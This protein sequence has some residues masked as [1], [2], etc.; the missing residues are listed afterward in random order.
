MQQ[1]LHKLT[2]RDPFEIHLIPPF[3]RS[4]VVCGKVK[5]NTPRFCSIAHNR[6]D[7][8]G[9]LLQ[10]QV[11]VEALQGC[12]WFVS[13]GFWNRDGTENDSLHGAKDYGECESRPFAVNAKTCEL[14]RSLL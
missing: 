6:T 12:W 1:N 14:G 2:V 9:K 11:R 10:C 7:Q 3:L 4:H 5:Q 8:N 13:D